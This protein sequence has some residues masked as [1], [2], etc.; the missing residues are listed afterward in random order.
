MAR[1]VCASGALTKRSPGFGAEPPGRNACA[2]F[3]RSLSSVRCQSHDT[4]SCTGQPSAAK[5]MAGCSSSSR[6]LVPCAASRVSQALTAPGMVTA[7]GL[8]FSMAVM[9]WLSNQ[10]IE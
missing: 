8:V 1:S 6:P 10:S 5:R 9:P 3:L 4:L 7:C 2:P